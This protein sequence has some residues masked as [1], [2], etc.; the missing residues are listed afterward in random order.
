MAVP[1]RPSRRSSCTEAF[2]RGNRDMSR[3]LSPGH[4]PK[5]HGGRSATRATVAGD[6]AAARD[7]ERRFGGAR[8]RPAASARRRARRRRGGEAHDLRLRRRTLRG[9]LHGARARRR[10]LDRGLA[11]RGAGRGRR[12]VRAPHRA[13]RR[14]ARRHGHDDLRGA[15]ER[16]A[17]RLV[18]S[19]RRLSIA[20]VGFHHGEFPPRA[21]CILGALDADG[22]PRLA[23]P[24]VCRNGDCPCASGA[25]T[26]AATASRPARPVSATRTSGRTEQVPRAAAR[27]GRDGGFAPR[28]TQE[29][30]PGRVSEEPPPD[31]PAPRYRHGFSSGVFG[32]PSNARVVD[33]VVLNN[34]TTDQTLRVTLYQADFNARKEPVDPPGPM[35]LTLQPGVTSGRAFSVGVKAEL[36]SAATTSSSSR[37][38]TRACCRASR[39]GTPRARR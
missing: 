17:L 38:T 19:A 33:I 16:T 27:I 2:S 21:Y 25:S 36:Q 7:R 18:P 5:G 6:D 28:H 37:W 29:Q 34:S 13:H 31:A 1:A 4:V 35:T 32:L 30:A 39:P 9:G 8:V 24:S 23:I 12:R 11:R 22:N 15:G 10:L 26:S 20:F 14:A 3:G